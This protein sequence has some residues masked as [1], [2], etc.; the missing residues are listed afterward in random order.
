MSLIVQKFGGTS[1]GS[2][3]R[4]QH[5]AN[6]LKET[7][8]NGNQV[9][10]VVSAMGKTTNQLVSLAREICEEPQKRDLDMLVTT[11]EQVT[12]SLLSIALANIG[13]EAVSLT[14]WQAGIKAEEQFG[15]ARITSID[16][17]RITKNLDKG[18]IVIVA[19]FQGVTENDEIVTLGRGGSDTSAVALAA[20]LNAEKCD[21]FTDV[22]GVFTTDP[23]IVD[24]ARKL[25]AISYDEM[26]ELA[27]LGAGVLHPRAVEFAKN[28]NITLEVR[29]SFKREA[30]TIVR[31]GVEMERNL[32]VR[33]IAFEEEVSKIAIHH[34]PNERN[35]LGNVFTVLADNGI[36]VDIIIQNV[37]DHDTTNLSFS[38]HSKEVNHAIAILKQYQEELG[39]TNITSETNLA[40]VSIVG[41]GM[42]SNHGVAAQMFRELASEGIF[43]KMVTTSEIKVSTVIDREDMEKAVHKLHDVFQLAEVVKTES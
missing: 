42:I 10:V 20:A 16:T 11:G 1:V 30:G 26:L 19:G 6:L 23:R 7:V 34:L 25:P 18:K 28:Y 33:G 35:A 4:I 21:I 22:T 39:F 27:N 2:V 14:G 32:I 12:I 24:G 29:S 9:V 41:S 38:T 3:E 31:E 36:N 43:V 15:N 5:V 13:I 37:N 8:E 40:K 17:K